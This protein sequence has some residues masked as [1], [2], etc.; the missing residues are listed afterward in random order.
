MSGMYR[1]QW[2]REFYGQ[3]WH[4]LIV[5]SGHYIENIGNTTLHYL[6]IFK[7]GVLFYARNHWCMLTVIG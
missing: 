4:E 3:N 6:E 7:T 2:V 5:R 1:P